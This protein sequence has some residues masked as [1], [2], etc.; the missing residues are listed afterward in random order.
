MKYYAQRLSKGKLRFY[1]MRNYAHF[2]QWY[3]SDK[4]IYSYYEDI[5]LDKKTID[6][7]YYDR[8]NLEKLLIRQRHGGNSFFELSNF[9][10]FE[11]FHRLFI[12][13]K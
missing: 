3:R 5:L 4:R 13:N 8:D 7:G 1:D 11:L 12:D 9:L 2:S 6:R 10:A